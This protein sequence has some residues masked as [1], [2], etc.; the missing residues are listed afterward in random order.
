VNAFI[1]DLKNQP[2]E[3]AK[4]T[5]AIAAKGIDITGFSGATCA[6]TG[7]VALLTSD[8]AGTRQVLTDGHWTYRPIEVVT[9]SLANK[10][11]S[12]AQVA[13]SLANAGINIEATVPTNM[14]GGNVHVGFLTDNPAKT[15]EALGSALLEAAYSR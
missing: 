3:L 12:L 4:V 7:T 8:E 5:E 14:A 10:P 6:D 1:V 15:R 2:G 13:R 9:A 11:G